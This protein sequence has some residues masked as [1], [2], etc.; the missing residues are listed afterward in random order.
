MAENINVQLKSYTI[1]TEL[2]SYT[3]NT[4]VSVGARGKSA[5]ESWLDQGNT[6]TEAQFVAALLSNSTFTFNQ[7]VAS[8]EWTITHNLNKFP[9]VTII[10]SADSVVYGEV[11]YNSANSLTISFT[12]DFSGKAYLN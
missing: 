1:D 9:S 6:G 7:Q 8:S 5:Y 11:Q 2:K 3:L 10:D 12:A 4:T